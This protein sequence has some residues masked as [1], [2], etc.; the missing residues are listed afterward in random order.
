MKT[1]G[2]PMLSS[3]LRPFTV[4]RV[5]CAQR[6]RVFENVFQ[7]RASV[8]VVAGA[9]RV[10]H[11]NAKGL[12]RGRR[13]MW[14]EE[15]VPLLLKYLDIRPG[16]HVADV[17]CGTGYFT[18]LIARGLKGRGSIVG[19]DRN[20]RLLGFARRTAAEQGLG[21]VAFKQGNAY[22]LPF[23]D[24]SMDRVVCQTTLWTLANP[25]KALGEMKRVC[26]PGGL[27]GAVEGAFDHVAW[28]MPD[29]QRLTELY[30]KS[31]VAQT[32]GHRKLSGADGG[33]GYKLPAL[34]AKAG[35]ARI[36][37]DAYPYVW[38]ESDDRV[39]VKSKLEEHTAYVK[40]YKEEPSTARRAREKVMLAGG[41]KKDEIEE[42]QQLTY[43]R[44]KEIVENP[45]LLG[46]DFSVNGGLF[47]ICTGKKM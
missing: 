21:V 5:H 8:S 10:I 39:P 44:S 16:Q 3:V 2:D 26:M 46:Q 45:R 18:R 30:R 41:M 43:E 12:E 23:K 11:F 6:L 28:Y 14:R 35:L 1:D 38:L 20:Q 15:Y 31:V 24:D 33:I 36:R 9:R 4:Y 7:S 32:K 27:V 17:G 29:N 19:V 42:M 25:V 13:H 37:L 47:F 22:S 40:R 34:F